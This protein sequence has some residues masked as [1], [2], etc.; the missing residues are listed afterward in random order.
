MAGGFGFNVSEAGAEG[1]VGDVNLN[2]VGGLG[3]DAP[4]GNFRFNASE[5]KGVE[6]RNAEC[7]G[8]CECETTIS[9]T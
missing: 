1:D 7:V 3:F 6:S 9:G 8:I 4:A 2:D 5:W